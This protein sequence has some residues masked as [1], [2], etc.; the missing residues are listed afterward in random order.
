[1]QLTSGAF[2]ETQAIPREYTCDGMNQSPELKIS[3]APGGT[4]SLT[5]IFDD[6][7]APGGTF[8]HWLAYDIEP[9]DRI[10]ENASPG[11]QGVNDFGKRGYGGPCPPSGTHRYFFR[12]YAL[13]STVDLPPG[14]GR[15]DVEGAMEGH[16]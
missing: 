14:S 4:R 9:T 11:T 16:V 10:P 12:V 13:D 2:E 7:D 5:L 3:D 1:M 8:L 6:P 15:R